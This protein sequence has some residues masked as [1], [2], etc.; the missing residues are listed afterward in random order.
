MRS[1]LLLL[2]FI[3]GITT[4]QDSFQTI[5]EEGEGTVEIRFK[6]AGQFV[7]ETQGEIQGAE[8]EILEDIFD[9][10]EEREGVTINRNYQKYD[11]FEKMYESVAGNP[12][13]AGVFSIC[14]YSITAERLK[15]VKF[16]PSY[17]PDIEVMISS[18]DLPVVKDSS[19][20][21]EKFK[22]AKAI[23]VQGSTFEE[24]IVSLGELIPN[25]QIEYV[26]SHTEVI[27]KII[28]SQNTFGFLELPTYL[29]LF[30]KGAKVNRQNLFAVQR[31]G[32]GFIYPLNSDWH[33]VVW[34]YFQDEDNK[35]KV[36][37]ILLKYFSLEMIE[38]LNEVNSTSGNEMQVLLLARE[39]DIEE[40]R[41]DNQQLLIDNERL[42][43][44]KRLAEADAVKVYLY[45]GIGALIIVLSLS[46]LAYYIKAK[47]HK[48]ISRQKEEV[49]KQKDI[50]FEKHKMITDSIHYAKTIQNAMLQGEEHVNDQL[51]DHFVFFAPKDVV[52][53]DFYWSK[54]I[55][56]H[57]YFAT[58]DCTGHGVPGGFMSVL[59]ISLLNDILFDNERLT[60]A[61][62][63]E[64][65]SER[66]IK[67]LDQTGE[68]GSSQ[69][70]MDISL[71]R[72]NLDTLELVWAGAYSPLYIFRAGELIELK[73]NK[74]PIGYY[75]SKKPFD[76]Q[77]LQLIKGDMIYCSTDG[78]PD[79]F[80]GERGKKLKSSGF[81]KLLSEVQMLSTDEQKNYLKR[82]FQDWKGNNDQIDDACVI[83][84]RV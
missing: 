44:D 40:L 37:T 21:K 61:E 76:N 68:D 17:L 49:E 2:I 67:E 20:L 26:S 57:C 13:Y 10:V 28:T 64:K 51:P 77:K 34:D 65:L 16:S 29:E 62:I 83:G 58:V 6:G 4:A 36:R 54:I 32:Y 46:G 27:E 71:A 14:S 30:E 80:G 33:G 73:G 43:N 11:D 59:G 24:D 15:S 48:V 38:F 53:G 70:G 56:E 23:T 84:M 41:F 31:D 78:Y 60:P 18:K 42:A 22:Y 66:V 8:Y 50:I 72:I 12:D 35:E 3:A 82:H 45:F 74:Q 81:K 5:L 1:V 55:N 19:E 47:D 69:D 7:Y 52:S 75:P 9:W 25:I 79:Q 39:K 63:L